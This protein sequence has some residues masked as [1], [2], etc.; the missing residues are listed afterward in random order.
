LQLLT[1]PTHSSAGLADIP[2]ALI[3]KAEMETMLSDHKSAVATL[4]QFLQ[5]QPDNALGLLNRANSEMQ[6]TNLAAAKSDYLKVQKTLHEPSYDALQ[7]LG[8]IAEQEHNSS[9]AAGFYKQY[10]QSAPTN[11]ATYQEVKERLRHLESR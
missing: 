10:M 7:G 2:N 1:S 9:E 5:L 11:L 6:I 3:R 4:T 8:K